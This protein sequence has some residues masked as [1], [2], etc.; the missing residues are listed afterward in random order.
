M[1]S[2]GLAGAFF[3]GDISNSYSTS[4]VFVESLENED[5]DLVLS[6]GFSGA[7]VG[8]VSGNTVI[9]NVYTTGSIEGE[10]VIGGFI[11]SIGIAPLG[12]G[13]PVILATNLTIENA[14]ALGL[15]AAPQDAEYV[16]GFIGR[17]GQDDSVIVDIIS[18]YWNTETS[19]RS[20]SAGG[21]GK[22]TAEMK[23]I[24]TYTGWDIQSSTDDRLQYPTLS[25]QLD[26]ETPVWLI[27][28]APQVSQPRRSSGS[29]T[30]QS[31]AL[32]KQVFSDYYNQSETP[33]QAED[34]LGSG[35]CPANLIVTDNM[36]QGDRDGRYS[37]YNQG[38]VTQVALLQ[39]HIN[40]ILAAQ[41][42]QAAGPVDGIYGPLTKQGVER[43]Q[44]V[45]NDILVPTP[46]LVIDGIVGPFT[47]DAINNS[48]GD[49]ASI[50]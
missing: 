36:K 25:W 23:N 30:A 26:L 5:D 8:V 35:L 40:R 13:D 21:M 10:S 27:Y 24:T 49:V 47:K 1:Y 38:T 17:I 9:T 39:F 15:V 50:S 44:A 46:L 4:R 2:G 43:L 28:Q 31:R 41:Y 16:G 48:C 6:G 19:G 22:T 18:S 3:G 37:S 42:D 7:F 34:I 11:G 29:S 32:A 33:S 45:L 14:Y 20:E 12:E